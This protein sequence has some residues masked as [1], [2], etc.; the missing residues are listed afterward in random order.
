MER[1]L[2][3][4]R[5]AWRGLWHHRTF[6][7]TAL[8]ALVGALVVPGVF[9]VV[10]VNTLNAAHSLGDR[11]ELVV[12]LREGVA[13]ST[14]ET[15][16][17]RLSGVA[18]SVTYVSKEEAWEEMARE[19]GGSELLEAVGQN[20]LPAS[21]RVRLRPRYLNYASMDSIAT[22]VGNEE[23]VEEVQFGGEWVRRLDRFFDTLRVIGFGIGAVIAL[24]VL[25]VVSNTIRLTVVARREIHRVM[26]LM[27]ASSRFVRMP[28]VLEGLLVSVLAAVVALG[29]LYGLF[30]LLE[31][32]LAVLPVFLPWRWIVAFLLTAG[33][34][35]ALG[36]AL[37]VSRFPP[38]ER[39]R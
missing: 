31:P 4:I 16:A 17:R 8:L 5:E 37:A 14:R 23:A 13:D 35:G 7:W 29:L 39:V 24:V 27:G 10:L 2:Y 21:Y 15:L 20:P 1:I 6:T 9:L 28:L 22:S 36:S 11:R 38:E 34:L 18:R 33:V 3:F 12:F 25:F 19:L 32:R 26:L 30:A